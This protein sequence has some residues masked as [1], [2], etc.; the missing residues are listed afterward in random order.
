[1][2]CRIECQPIFEDI[3]HGLHG[4]EPDWTWAR[5]PLARRM[6]ADVY[7][8]M[9][10]LC[11]HLNGFCDTAPMDQ[12]LDEIDPFLSFEPDLFDD[13]KYGRIVPDV[14]SYEEKIRKLDQSFVVAPLEA[15]KRS[16][17]YSDALRRE[18]NRKRE[19]QL[20]RDRIYDQ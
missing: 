20:R 4:H 15:V 12:V 9:V 16:K 7:L 13:L 1:M 8:A 10:A 18:E 14:I 11:Q 2:T 19:E 3:G 17:R 5:V 6:A